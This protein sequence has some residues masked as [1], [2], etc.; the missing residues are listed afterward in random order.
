MAIRADKGKVVGY[1]NKLQNYEVTDSDI[2]KL[3]IEHGLYERSFDHLQKIRM[4]S[5]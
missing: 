5:T 4:L 3:A 1:I 2:A